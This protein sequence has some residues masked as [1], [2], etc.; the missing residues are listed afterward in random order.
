MRPIGGSDLFD[1]LDLELDAAQEVRRQG[2]AV[3]IG[4][5]KSE[6][7][8]DRAKGRIG[9]HRFIADAGNQS[10]EER[11]HAERD[12]NDPAIDGFT[13]RIVQD[14][15][16]LHPRA[17]PTGTPQCGA[18]RGRST[19]GSAASTVATNRSSRVCRFSTR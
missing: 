5:D 3:P 16:E 18:H 12:I 1:L 8:G 13:K 4:V 2:A 7:A 6:L 9:G 15:Q 19:P 17:P 10:D 11:R 14:R